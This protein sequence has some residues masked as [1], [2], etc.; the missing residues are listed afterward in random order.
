MKDGTKKIILTIL[1]IGVVVLNLLIR[2]LTGSDIG[3]D[4]VAT[5]ALGAMACA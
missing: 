3:A 1:N 5:V 2:A 4:I